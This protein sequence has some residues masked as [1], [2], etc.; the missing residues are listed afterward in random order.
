MLYTLLIKLTY[1]TKVKCFYLKHKKITCNAHFL[2]K[3]ITFVHLRKPQTLNVSSVHIM[4]KMLC[5][6]TFFTLQYK[7]A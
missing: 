3:R 7:I 4:S 6:I 1:F 2:A 5:C